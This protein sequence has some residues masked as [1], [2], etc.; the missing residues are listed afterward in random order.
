MAYDDKQLYSKR[1]KATEYKEDAVVITEYR[2]NYDSDF[3]YVNKT[4]KGK[5]ERD[6]KI[7]FNKN[8]KFQ[9]GLSWFYNARLNSFSAENFLIPVFMNETVTSVNYFFASLPEEVS[10]S[11][12]DDDINGVRCNGNANFVGVFGLTGEFAGWFSNDEARV[13]LK[14]QLNVVIGNITLELDSFKRKG[15]KPNN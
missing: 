15:W 11:L 5:T 12:F 13:P 2:F 6:E 3:V 14:S 10:I 4:N 8:I 7:N 9:D 1:F